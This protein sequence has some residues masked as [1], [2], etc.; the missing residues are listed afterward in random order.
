MESK[1]SST[2]SVS[3]PA[4]MFY[5]PIFR[6]FVA[7]TL[8]RAGFTERFAYRTEIIVDEL[9]TNAIRYGSR[10]RTS[11]IEIRLTWYDDRIDLSITDEGGNKENIDALQKVINTELPE[12]TEFKTTG[13]S[14]G[15]EIV[16]MLSEKIDVRVLDNNITSIHITRKREAS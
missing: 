5:V 12:G 16:K 4:L 14:L 11:R 6:E 9:C 8:L 15:L 10:E 7:D 3:L 13:D 1:T 2:V